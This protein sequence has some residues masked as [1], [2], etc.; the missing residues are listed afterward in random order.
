MSG[1]IWSQVVGHETALERLARDAA[2]GRVADAYLFA[3]PGGVGKRTVAL[4]FA[5][6]LCCTAETP[7]CGRCEACRAVARLVP[8]RIQ[9]VL[10][11]EQA[12]GGVFKVRF[13]P[14][15][16]LRQMQSE[17]AL[18]G[19]EP[20]RRV[21]IID[22]AEAMREE[23]A[24]SLLKTLEE[25]PPE[26][27]MILLSEQP[28]ALL[29]TVLS[30][31]RRID[32]GPVPTAAVAEWLRR[33]HGVAP[34]TAQTLAEVAAGRPGRALRLAT[35][36]AATA[37]RERVIADLCGLARAPAAAALPTARA[38]LGEDTAGGPGAELGGEPTVVLTLDVI[39]W[40]YRDALVSRCGGDGATL[41]N[42]DRLAEV[43]AFG[44]AR[45][46]AELRAG[47]QALGQARQSLQRNANATLAIEV[48][49]LRLRR[50]GM[51]VGARGTQ[52]AVAS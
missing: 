2:G 9:V 13:H 42:S 22:A 28:A 24:N 38:W 5:Q 37:H 17:I 16:S 48:L 25:P 43:Q 47:L 15:D 50:G 40:W 11:Q 49:W 26:V 46:P 30:R 19:L 3:G 1:A 14:I 12:G 29:P 39:E 45:S 8:G 51:T 32:F 33:A 6:R 10:P 20:G 31:L 27:V 36:P 18:R 34:G 4:G 52:A 44:A 23:A 41:V 35:D 21:Y 7:P